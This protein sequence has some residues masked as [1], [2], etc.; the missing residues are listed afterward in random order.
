[1]LAGA[2]WQLLKAQ[3]MDPVFFEG[4][5]DYKS[6]GA[7]A[8]SVH[9]EPDAYVQLTGGSFGARI[10]LRGRAANIVAAESVAREALAIL[11]AADG[12]TVTWVDEWTDGPDRSYRL[13]AISPV[14]AQPVPYPTPEVGEEVSC[15]CR[16]HVTEL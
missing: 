4:F 16:L 2:V 14:N 12:S 9:A 10:Q 6:V 1:M 8:V 15:N 13:E 5:G 7:P 11:M 3:G